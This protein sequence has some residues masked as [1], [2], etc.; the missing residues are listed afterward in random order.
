MDTSDCTEQPKKQEDVSR[1]DPLKE[2]DAGSANLRI[3]SVHY[4]SEPDY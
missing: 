1:R 3:D 2:E 4:G